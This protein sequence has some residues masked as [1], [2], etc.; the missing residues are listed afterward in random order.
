MDSH[1]TVPDVQG[2]IDAIR[3]ERLR[4]R[5][6]LKGEARLRR[7]VVRGPVARLVLPEKSAEKKPAEVQ[8]DSSAQTASFL[9]KVSLS[10]LRVEKAQFGLRSRKDSLKVDVQE[11]GFSVRDI[12]VLLAENSVEYNDSSYCF[13]LDSLDFTDEL[14]LSRIRIGHLATCDAGPVEGLGIHLFNCVPMEELAERMGKV[15]S[16]W[17]DVK[18]DSL[19]TNP[20]NIPRLVKNQRVEIGSVHLSSPEMVLFQDDRYPPAVPYTTLQEGL[21]TLD[22]PLHVGKID[23]NI[24]LFTF[25]WE[26][27]HINRGTL[28]LH[29]VRVAISSVSNARDNVMGLSIRSGKKGTGALNLSTYIRNDRQE[30][31]HGELHI[32]DMDASRL[33]SFIRPLFGATVRAD[34]H[35]IDGTFKGNKDQMTE[36][37]CMLYDGLSIKAWDDVDAPFKIMAQNSGAVTFLANLIVPNANP[38][39]SGK[40]PKMV[41]VTFKR[42]P[43][44][45][46]PV[47]L[48]QNLTMGM[49]RTVLPSGAIHKDDKKK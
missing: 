29:N 20:L 8:Q 45:P 38:S 9:K 13:S 21:N 12:S 47:Y 46:Y 41:G 2:H 19:R 16:V 36:N 40:E 48:I 3:L 11:V 43:M 10:E 30:S 6:L 39:K 4:W 22:L 42:D 17:Y 27:T 24:K 15:S 33:D 34:I 18:L 5:S 14:G 49:L 7:L 35:Q 37:F 28:P 26:T 1:H 25:I 31:T 44:Q 23:A 32:K